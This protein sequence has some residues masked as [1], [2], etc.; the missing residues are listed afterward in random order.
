MV[1]AQL[2]VEQERLFVLANKD[3]GLPASMLEGMEE[4]VPRLTREVVECG[5][6]VLWEKAGEVNEMVGKWLKKRVFEGGER[7]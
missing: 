4:F 1:Y 2:T 6:W 3:E 7:K 5:H